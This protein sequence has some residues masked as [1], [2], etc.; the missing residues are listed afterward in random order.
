MKKWFYKFFLNKKYKDTLNPLK[1]EKILILR[2]DRLGDMVVTLPLIKTLKTLNPNY[3]IDIV[4]SR[5]NNDIIKDNPL[6]EKIYIYNFRER[7]RPFHFLKVFKELRA[8]RYDLVIDPFYSNISRAGVQLK[9]INAKFNIGL[10]KKERYGLKAED[11]KLLYETVPFNPTQHLSENILNISTILGATQKDFKREEILDYIINYEKNAL[12]FL[13]LYKDKK[14]ILFN[15]QGSAQIRS[16]NDDFITTLSSKLTQKPKHQVIIMAMPDRREN[17]QN[18]LKKLD[19]S[20]IILANTKSILDATALIKYSHI[21]ISPDTSIVH[22]ASSFQK[23]II[24]FYKE[25]SMNQAIF[26]P[27]T[28]DYKMFIYNNL[29]TLT[30][31]DAK[32]IFKTIIKENHLG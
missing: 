27:Y 16:F 30:S 28:E 7:S 17:I 31:D 15:I 13:E 2:Y 8:E 24:S 32:S 1:I 26:A 5:L 6:I 23:K 18:I 10:S 3:K 9:M 20:Q 4:A 14:I 22:I 19:N 12:K 29:F 25:E 21:V 11:F